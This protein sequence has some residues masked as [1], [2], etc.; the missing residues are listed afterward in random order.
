MY[1]DLQQ[2][3][4]TFGSKLVALQNAKSKKSW[5][6]QYR[7]QIIP[8]IIAGVIVLALSG[9]V[10]LVFMTYEVKIKL[11]TQEKSFQALPEQVTSLR[12]SNAELKGNV[13][14]V[15]EA[16]KDLKETT[17]ELKD[18]R[19]DIRDRLEKIRDEQGE[20]KKSLEVIKAAVVNVPKTSHLIH[21]ISEII[22][23]P[24][25]SFALEGNLFVMQFPL[26]E[27]LKSG[28][29]IRQVRTR[30]LSV[31]QVPIPRINV[32]AKLN[33]PSYLL[34]IYVPATSIGGVMPRDLLRHILP[35]VQ[36]EVTYMVDN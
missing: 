12:L 1:E 20:F 19:K 13:D 17:K 4:P 6:N 3:I 28:E 31:P 7:D 14:N 10:T 8:K 2:I 36:V 22:S 34:Q 16:V 18:E 35:T 5:W 11:D 9:I 27:A 23:V 29:H 15:R 32:E 24:G 30:L 25:T 26:P 33:P 21:E